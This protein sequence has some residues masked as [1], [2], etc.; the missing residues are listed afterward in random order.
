M[1]SRSFSSEKKT[2]QSPTRSRKRPSSLPF[3]RFTSPWPRAAN[4][5]IALAILSRVGPSSLETVRNA[6]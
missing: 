2:L 1:R 3:N 6:R 5:S 4:D